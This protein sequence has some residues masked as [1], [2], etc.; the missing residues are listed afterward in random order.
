MAQIVF[1]Q[2][3][4]LGGFKNLSAVGSRTGMKF[5]FIGCIRKLKLNHRVFQVRSPPQFGDVL[6]GVDVGSY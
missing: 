3:L 4:F 1:K 5:G 2:D 6:S